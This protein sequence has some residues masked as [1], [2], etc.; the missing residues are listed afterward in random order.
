MA[1]FL[2]HDEALR[3]NLLARFEA[4]LENAPVPA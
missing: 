2:Q 4:W 3:A 1:A